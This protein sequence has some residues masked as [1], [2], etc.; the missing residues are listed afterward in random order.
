MPHLRAARLA[1]M[2]RIFHQ[3]MHGLGIFG[4]FKD[5]AEA[6]ARFNEQYQGKD[7]AYADA[8]RSLARIARLG[9]DT[10]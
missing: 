7:S 2:D 10:W 4:R 5:V 9:R 8:P 3:L 1:D 6:F